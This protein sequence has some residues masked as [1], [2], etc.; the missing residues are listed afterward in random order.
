MTA[1]TAERTGVLNRLLDAE[2]ERFRALHPRSAAAW[3]E[4]RQ[5]YLYGGP[6]H[7]MRRW[8]GGFPVYAE[9]AQGAHIRDI[10]GRDYIDFCLG[11]TGGMCGHAPEAVTEAAR[12]LSSSVAQP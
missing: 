12:S 6:S 9:E 3:Q 5:H 10:D 1:A 4:G 8:A 2:Q 11:D 7:W